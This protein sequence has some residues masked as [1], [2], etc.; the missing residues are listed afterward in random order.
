MITCSFVKSNPWSVNGTQS[1]GLRHNVRQFFT[2]FV[3]VYCVEVYTRKSWIWNYEQPI[4]ACGMLVRLD[5]RLCVCN[6][7]LC[8]AA[9]RGQL[10]VV[11]RW[12]VHLVFNDCMCI[13]K[14]FQ[15]PI[16]AKLKLTN[17]QS[18]QTYYFKSFSESFLWDFATVPSFICKKEQIFDSP[19]GLVR[20]GPLACRYFHSPL[21]IANFQPW[22]G[23]Q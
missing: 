21:A 22:T 5:F 9:Y 23:Y 1:A 19:S 20:K 10:N 4:T 18:C 2:P 14:W 12:F 7:Y 15:I 16:A 6:V 3:R 13:L 11:C 17:I 8:S